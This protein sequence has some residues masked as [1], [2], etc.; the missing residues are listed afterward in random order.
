MGHWALVK[1][2]VSVLPR[3]RGR[4]REAAF[5][6][7]D[8][9]PTCQERL[10]GL[11]EARRVLIQAENV[12][13]LDEIW[14]SIDKAIKAKPAPAARAFERSERRRGSRLWR[15]AAAGGIAGAVAVILLAL[16]VLA[17]R[18]VNYVSGA[19]RPADS[20]R[21]LTAS[22][23]GQPAELYVVEVPEDQMILVWVEK[24]SDKGDR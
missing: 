9:C 1:F 5:R 2:A 22:G 13:R 3:G 20:L 14:P 24:Q 17:P 10:V 6:H 7:I 8:H 4:E 12:G 23:A 19:A 21:I 15:W 11:G 16:G 18:S